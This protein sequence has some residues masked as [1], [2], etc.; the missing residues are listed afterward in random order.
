MEDS[1]GQHEDERA[2]PVTYR[3]EIV[4]ERGGEEVRLRAGV[5]GTSI[6]ELAED[7]I[8]QAS[9]LE[10]EAKEKLDRAESERGRSQRAELS[11]RRRRSWE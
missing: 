3:A 11:G 1:P 9:E 6:R 8:T 7:L 10:S 5:H 2:V 4:A